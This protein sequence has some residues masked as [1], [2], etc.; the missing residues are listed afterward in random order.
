MTT[1]HGIT[2]GKIILVAGV[3]AAT[4]AIAAVTLPPFQWE[5]VIVALITGTFGLIQ[6]RM[7]SKLHT[8]VNSQQ[9]TLNDLARKDAIDAGVQKGIGLGVQQ[10]RDAVAGKEQTAIA[11]QA[12][13]ERT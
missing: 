8:M 13:G 6:I 11:D 4:P 3:T 2:F 5:S 7:I 12:K 9:S 1:V 10:E